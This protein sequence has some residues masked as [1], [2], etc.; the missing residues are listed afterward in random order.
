MKDEATEIRPDDLLVGVDPKSALVMAREI[1]RIDAEG[2]SGGSEEERLARL[3]YEASDICADWTNALHA[4]KEIP[5]V[6]QIWLRIG[7]RERVEITRAWGSTIGGT[8]PT[9]AVRCRPLH[10]GKEWWAY[11]SS[12]VQRFDLETPDA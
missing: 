11:V 1:Q 6:G 5:G 10:G 3:I 7:G 4:I 8:A 2:G 9:P 12:F